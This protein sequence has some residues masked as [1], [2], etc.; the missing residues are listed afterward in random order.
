MSY[1]SQFITLAGFHSLNYSMYEL[2]RG[3]RDRGMAAYSELQ[4][5][6]FAAE[7]HGYTAHRQQREVGVS[8]YDAI[9]V[10]VKS[11]AS[12]NTALNDSN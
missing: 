6:A 5:T 10:A 8:W 9:S 11:G 2:S 1:K 3:C 12:S 7:E 4:N